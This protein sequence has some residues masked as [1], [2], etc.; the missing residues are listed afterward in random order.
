MLT[1]LILPR[2][3]ES[4]PHL[5]HIL[6]S[7]AYRYGGYTLTVGVGGWLHPDT[8]TLIEEPIVILEVLADPFGEPARVFFRSLAAEAAHEFS[9][10]SICLW[11]ADADPE[12]I[13][14]AP[15]PEPQGEQS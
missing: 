11:F 1:T 2:V 7:L 5:R 3:E 12:F 4:H 6:T 10:Q 8:G 14:P 13:G 9:Q 15:S